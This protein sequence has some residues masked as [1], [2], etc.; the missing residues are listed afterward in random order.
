[1]NLKNFKISESDMMREGI[2][3]SE[4]FGY[5]QFAVWRRDAKRCNLC[6]YK[7]NK[8]IEK[9]KM[10]SGKSFGA[11]DFFSVRLEASDIRGELEGVTYNFESDRVHFVDQYPR[12]ISGRQKFGKKGKDIR[13]C[14]VFDDFNWS[15]ERRKHI[16][17][18]EMIMYQCHLRGFT[19]HSSSGVKHPGTF[20]GFKEKI[21]YL[22]ELGVNTIVFLPIYDFNEI[23]TAE[24]AKSKEK[25]INFWGYTKD[26]CYFAPKASYASNPEEAVTE[27]KEMI[28]AL[29]MNGFNVIL[30]MHLAD[31]T[32][33]FI[34]ECLRFYA[35]EYHIDGFLVDTNIIKADLV[36]NDPILRHCKFLGNYWNTS[37][38]K[39]SS[40]IFAN[41][42]DEFLTISRRFLKSDEGQVYDFFNEFKQKAGDVSI[43][44]Y[45][46]QKSGFTLRDLVSYDVKHN[47]ANGEKNYDGTEYNYS[48]NCGQEG[49]SRKKVVKK[50]RFKQTKNA[51]SMLLLGLSTPMILAGD[52]FGRTQKGNNNAYCLDNTTTWIDWSGLE[53]NV[54]TFEFV[55]KLIAFRKQCG[56]FYC[57]ELTTLDSK[58]VGLPGIS[59]H[60]REPWVTDFSYYSRELGV[61]F[62]GSYYEGKSIYILFNFHWDSHEFYLPEIGKGD[63]KVLMSTEEKKGSISAKKTYDVEPRSIVVFEHD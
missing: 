29:H 41:Y 1:M 30:D 23:M 54:E 51:F 40:E 43:V 8:C 2:D 55:K 28:K 34:T 18:K 48:W 60:G 10:F 58:G 33:E 37:G 62:Y 61:L 49:P 19:K 15:G 38:G 44:H 42:N 24:E 46:T 47:D 11:T 57:D 4:K 45:I 35:I 22:K 6:L 16:P 25:K 31:K 5:V 56:V 3:L 63:W 13:G 27:C 39:A 12:L 21:S 20:L 53:K 50:M 14:F 7:D 17:F 52:E 36:E 26:A 59:N 32:V 9:I